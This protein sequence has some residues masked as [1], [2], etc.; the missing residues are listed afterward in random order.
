MT[1]KVPLTTSRIFWFW[2]PL[3]AMWWMMAVENPM[4]A[5]VIARLPEPELNLAM[6]G[7]TFSL[8]IIIESPI[9]ML[10]TAG[11][12]LARG[13]YSYERLLRFTH[14]LSWALT[15]LHLLIGL[16]PL[17]PL[18]VGSLMGVP[19]SI[20]EA[21]R[22]TFLL[23]IPWTAAI[24]Y[25][26]LWQGVLIRFNRTGVVPLTIM[27]RLLGSGII[28]GIGLLVGRFRGADLGAIA[29]SNSIYPWLSP[30]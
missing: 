30:H 8:A 22:P 2:L 7:V 23:M 28:L 1:E 15:A 20:L 19:D 17:Y 16:T 14:I 21:S 3:A 12:A 24:A 25:R 9:I 6:F 5:A 4:V 11:T 29:C 10:L 13:K 26:R 18:I 27:A